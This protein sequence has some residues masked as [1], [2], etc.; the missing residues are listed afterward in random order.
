EAGK[1]VPPSRISLRHSHSASVPVMPRLSWTGA[2]FSMPGSWR[3]AEVLSAP[4]R[5]SMGVF[6]LSSPVTSEKAASSAPLNSTTKL[7][8]EYGLPFSR[9][10]AIYISCMVGSG[11]RCGELADL[12]DHE[13]GRCDGRE[14]DFADET[15]VIDVILTH[16][17]A[18]ASDEECVLGF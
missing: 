17:G 1:V 18:V 4:S 9:G 11:C 10:V 15:A 13:F 7:K 14:P 5:Y 16:G 2:Y 6:S 8:L 3:G 12:E